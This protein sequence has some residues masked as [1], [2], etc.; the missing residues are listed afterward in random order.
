MTH[1]LGPLHDEPWPDDPRHPSYQRPVTFGNIPD[2]GI[3]Q[4][5]HAAWCEA[6]PELLERQMA[7][8]RKSFRGDKPCA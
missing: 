8:M 1:P 4:E 2:N 7:E 6:N 3:T 5:D